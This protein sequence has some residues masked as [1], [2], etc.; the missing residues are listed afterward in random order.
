MKEPSWKRSIDEQGRECIDLSAVPHSTAVRFC[1][2]DTTHQIPE[3]STVTEDAQGLL[4]ELGRRAYVIGYKVVFTSLQRQDADTAEVTDDQGRTWLWAPC[5]GGFLD[6]IQ[7]EATGKNYLH[8]V[9]TPMAD[10]LLPAPGCTARIAWCKEQDE[11]GIEFRRMRA[12]VQGA[13]DPGSQRFIYYFTV[14]L[15]SAL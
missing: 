14:I 9:D 11:D 12:A 7:E 13:S 1:F 4:I 2:D 6:H 15:K 5:R 10:P 8:Q 3:H